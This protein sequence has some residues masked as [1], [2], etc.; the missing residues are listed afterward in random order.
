MKTAASETPSE[1]TPSIGTGCASTKVAAR[2]SA[3]TPPVTASDG[4]EAAKDQAA[5]PARANPEAETGARRGKS[6]AV[7][8]DTRPPGSF[9]PATRPIARTGRRFTVVPVSPTRPSLR[10]QRGTKPGGQLRR[11]RTQA[12]PSNAA[13][14]PFPSP[15]KVGRLRR[16]EYLLRRGNAS[17]PFL[18]ISP[19]CGKWPR[20]RE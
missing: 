5:R 17:S 1:D 7:S 2:R 8:F 14:C 15:K 3:S 18:V 13:L 11:Q 9:L 19:A 4:D 20:M 12:L 16:V 6:R 10:P